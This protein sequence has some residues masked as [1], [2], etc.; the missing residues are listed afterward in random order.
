MIKCVLFKMKTS[1][2]F[3]SS[4]LSGELFSKTPY[5]H[6][7]ALKTGNSFAEILLQ[8]NLKSLKT[9]QRQSVSPLSALIF[10]QYVCN[11]FENAVCIN[12]KLSFLVQ[13]RVSCD[14]IGGEGGTLGSDVTLNSWRFFS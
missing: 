1:V 3:S 4:L 7:F 11:F 9:F 13:V 8:S 12:S 14:Q 5:I 2:S 6:M 10:K